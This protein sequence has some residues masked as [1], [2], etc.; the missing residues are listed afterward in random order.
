MTSYP[1]ERRHV[2][3]IT[4]EEFEEKYINR[5]FPVI[6]QGLLDSWPAYNLWTTEYFR[7]KLGDVEVHWS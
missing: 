4:A 6:L 7:T 3:D 2:S 5:A 1:I